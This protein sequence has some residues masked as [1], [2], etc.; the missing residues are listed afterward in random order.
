MTNKRQAPHK[1][2]SPE[3]SVPTGKLA[4]MKE[5][6]G[7][8]AIHTIRHELGHV[9]EGIAAG[10]KQEGICSSSH[11][12]APS[13]TRAGVLWN[14]EGMYADGRIK[15]E[16]RLAMVQTALG[17]IA[18][19]EVFNDL[20]R[21]ANHNFFLRAGGDG[22][23][24]YNILIDAGYTHE[25]A[26]ER[27]HQTIDEGVAHLKH[28]AVTSV[29]HENAGVREPGLSRQFHYSPERLNS[30]VAEANRRMTDEKYTEKQDDRTAN[31][32]T[33]RGS[34][35]THAGGEG[36]VSEGAGRESQEKVVKPG[37][38]K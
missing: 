7:R 3:Y 8:P 28:P 20:P 22:T 17:A 36:A 18:A 14:S 13:N 21:S 30:M 19:D 27:M 4:K 33:D 15:P 26:M 24:A 9:F 35:T 38:K 11:P 5:S 32:Q 6:A 2:A 23:K 31:G 34:E 25:G 1:A 16:K 12:V 10:M 37:G 29:V